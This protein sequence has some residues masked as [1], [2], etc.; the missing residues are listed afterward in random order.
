GR[1][2]GRSLLVTDGECQRPAHRELAVNR[3]ARLA[4][5]DRAAQSLERAFERQLVSRPHDPLEPDVID[6]CEQR[7]S[8]AILFLAQHRD[9]SGLSERLDHLHAGHDG[10]PGEMTGAVLVR[11][12]LERNDM[13]A[14]FELDDLVQKEERRTVREYL[15][16]LRAP[17]RRSD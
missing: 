2:R 8:A 17:K 4:T 13:R 15:L 16:D 14:G 5:A 12:L 3:C 10:V 9:G 7:E 11:D 6:T 1:L